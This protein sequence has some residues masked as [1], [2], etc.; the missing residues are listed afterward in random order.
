M[1]ATAHRP[2]RLPRLCLPTLLAAS[3]AVGLSA[4]AMAQSAPPSATTDSQQRSFDIVA[5][6][7]DTALTRLADQAGVRILF[8]SNEVAALQGPRLAGRF[9]VEQALTRLLAGSG[10]DWHWREPGIAVVS[11]AAAGANGGPV[12]LDTLTVAG[13]RPED[14][15]GAQRDVQGHDDVYYLDA[16]TAYLGRAEVERYKGTTPSDLL[17]GVAGV[18]SGDARNSGALDVNIRGLQGPGRVPVTI[19]GTEQATTA[20]RGYNGIA[21][22]NYIDPTLIGGLQIFKGPT[23]IR[24]VSSGVGGAVV[25]RTLDVDDI[26]ADGERF[27]AEFKAEGSSNATSPRLPG[28]LYTGQNIAD[29]PELAAGNVASDP[30]LRVQPRT[31]GGSNNMLDGGDVA[32]RLAMGWKGDQLS[33]MGAYAYR[34]RGN[35]FAGSNNAGYYDQDADGTA[36]G[37]YITT[38]AQR[39]HP[40]DEVTNTSSRMTSWLFKATWTPADDQVLQ[41][42]FRDTRST[43]GEIMPSRITRTALGL[44]QWPLSHV[45][46]TAYN[47]EYKWQPQGNRWLDLYANAWRTN[48]DSRSNTAGSYPNY[49]NT[50]TQP[51]ILNG[52][53]DD[54]TNSRNGITLSNRFVLHDTLDLT[55]GGDFQHEKQRSHDDYLGPSAAWRM[56]PRSGRREEWNAN[57][58]FEWRPVDFLK[59]NIGARYS[60]YWAQDDFLAAH[61]DTF[62][63]SVS[64]YKATYYTLSAEDRAR[65][66]ANSTNSWQACQMFSF[67]CSILGVTPGISLADHIASKM[68]SYAR[69]QSLPWLADA[70]GRFH[71]A[72]NPCT[73][74][75]LDGIADLLESRGCNVGRTANPIASAYATAGK[76]SDRGWAPSFTATAFLSDYSRLY[77][78][79]NE[80]KRY[81]SMF[82][83]VIA[84]GAS[85]NPFNNLKPEH[86]YSY[87]LGYVHELGHL[88]AADTVADAKLTW[89]H[90]R[91]NDLIERDNNF[92]FSNIDKQTV[93][94]VELQARFDNG[95]LFTDLAVAKILKNRVCDEHTAITID[96]NV[97][98]TPDCVDEG[99]LGS[100][101]LTQAIPALSANWSLGGRFVD[102]R[103]ELGTRV[104]YYQRRK[105]NQDYLDFIETTNQNL[106][107]FNVPFSWGTTLLFDAYA[108]YRINDALQL[109]LVGSNLGNRYYADP[110]T[111]SL[112]PAP[113]RTLKLSLT[114][115]F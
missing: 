40:G 82:E 113:G 34:D 83:S 97:T 35:Y 39:L 72:D 99:F 18:F 91:T 64:G 79:Y 33:L 52:A 84:F 6:P 4:P 45:D 28:R 112:L 65:G 92:L 74:G 104:T 26:V 53:L 103:L 14:A 85:I 59:F 76:R 17:N 41:F 32:Y 93:Q 36:A 19:D 110:A 47:L 50:V 71:R 69:E 61:P 87:E 15:T 31:G 24:N 107:V 70:D 75:A 109:E 43:H 9:S 2:V 3:I 90:R 37:D 62:L 21:N 114:A 108:S 78:S 101:L 46:S 8:A 20:W 11:R 106:A 115:R 23:M 42:G 105:Q 56:L 12:V 111:R 98:S 54:S 58:S 67:Y 27:G 68:D 22:R 25:I 30:T 29:V 10:L 66:E 80:L 63:A 57:V 51:I 49:W 100:W 81:P 38:L 7:L 88:F 94:G 1:T 55:V 60:A 102:R 16:S 73:N 44:P 5:Q 96:P 48:S 86:V 77:A 13:Q 89:Y 95:R